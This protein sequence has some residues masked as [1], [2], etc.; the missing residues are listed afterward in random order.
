MD[1]KQ[2]SKFLNVQFCKS[3][4]YRTFTLTYPYSFYNQLRSTCSIYKLPFQVHWDLVYMYMM[5]H[6][7]DIV[8]CNMVMG[9]ICTC[10]FII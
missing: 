8:S 2:N 9:V 3:Q 7:Y 4:D 6:R 1:T 5:M 10:N